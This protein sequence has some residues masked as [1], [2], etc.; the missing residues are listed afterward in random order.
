MPV[1]M[2][3]T[4]T[5]SGPLD[6]EAEQVPTDASAS[7][8]G[9]DVHTVFD[10]AAVAATARDR[11]GGRPSDD[12]VVIE[13]HEA[14]ISTVACVPGLPGWRFGL[15]GGIAGGD[16]SGVDRGDFGPVAGLQCSDFDSKMSPH[17]LMFAPVRRALGEGR[18][19]DGVGSVTTI[20]KK[21]LHRTS[22]SGYNETVVVTIDTGRSEDPSPA[23]RKE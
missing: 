5:A 13:G 1:W 20:S 17:R 3:Q 22:A 7:V 21:L 10:D 19:T 16:P 8:V 15:E 23:A 14:Q 9:V 2:V 4:P 11:A 18:P 12:T 6:E